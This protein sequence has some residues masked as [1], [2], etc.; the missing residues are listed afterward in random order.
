VPSPVGITASTNDGNVPANAIDN[1]LATRWSGNGDGAWL[2]VDLQTVRTVCYVKIAFFNGASRQHIFDIHASMAS[3]G[4]WTNL[5][6]SARSSGTTTALETFELTDAD[7]RYV[8][9]LGHGNTDPLKST[10]NS[11]S[12]FKVFVKPI[13]T[14][15]TETPTPTP[16][17]TETPMPTPT[18]TP[19]A[20]PSPT[21]TPTPP[22]TYVEITPAAG[23]VTAS[24]NDGNLPSNVV[25]DNLATRWSGNGDGAWLQL[26]LGATY[27]V[28]HVGIAVYNGNSRHNRFDIQVASAASG[29]WTNVLTGELSSGN[30]TLEETHD[31]ADTSA[32]Y[33]RYL[34][35][36]SDVGTFNSV[37]EMSVFGAPCTSCPTPPPPTPTP[38]PGSGGPTAEELLAKMASCTQ[39]S[40]GT[41]KTDTEAAR[42]IPVCRATGGYWWKADMDIDCDGVQTTQCNRNTDP[43]YLPDTSLHTSTG[44]P[45]NAA[46]MPYVVI[47]QPNSTWSYSAKGISLGAVFAVIYNGKVEYGVFADTGPTDI[48]GEASYAMATKLGI[49][50]NPANGGTDGPVWYIVFPGSRVNPVESHSDAVAKGEALAR[51]FVNNN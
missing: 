16:T 24:T 11:V 39:D 3:A 23:G 47:P 46:T 8:R 28:G 31:F 38:T 34:G 33:V 9:Y 27:T 7:A 15:P 45:F 12:E 44:Q 30:T 25:D 20:T 2:Q 43:W 6:T 37:T 48:I 51:G 50:P 10:W 40:S 19:T 17:P 5:L 49:N 21:A 35:H 18:A 26:D 13:G 36:M 41:F 32:R 1:D 29:P 4:P 22:S 14:T 42:T